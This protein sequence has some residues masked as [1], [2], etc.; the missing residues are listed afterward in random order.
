MLLNTIK[1]LTINNSETVQ[2]ITYSRWF[3]K[4][5]PMLSIQNKHT[6]VM[7]SAGGK[8]SYFLPLSHR[9]TRT[10]PKALSNLSS[11]IIIMSTPKKITNMR[12]CSV[13][14]EISNALKKK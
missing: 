12:L 6:R 10:V 8:C 7:L 11:F 3:P 13:D 5:P 9:N 4:E 1:L 14:T 2:L